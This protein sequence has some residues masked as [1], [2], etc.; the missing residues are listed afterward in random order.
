MKKIQRLF[1]LSRPRFWLYELGPYAIGVLAGA[2]Q[3]AD[4]QD[5]RIFVFAVFFLFPANL[6]IYG[7]NDIFDYETDKL[8]PKKQGYEDLLEPKLH[9]F[10]WKAIGLMTLPFLFFLDWSNGSQI[11]WFLL[12]LFFAGFYSAEPIRAKTKSFLD[13]FFSAGHYVA[14]AVFGY[15]LV[16]GGDI[17]WQYVIAGVLRAMAM[18]A[19]SAIPDIQADREAHMNTVAT[20][21]EKNWTLVYCLILYGLA[22]ILVFTFLGWVSLVLGAVYAAMMIASFFTDDLM[23]LYRYFPWLNSLVGMIL[24]FVVALVHL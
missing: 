7:I 16:S 3:V 10:V 13:G 6:Y 11:F 23:K 20:V 15:V 4:L 14:T 21:L 24:F 9:A 2:L 5:W 12:F 22:A 8:N 1:S 18:H 19:Y 17:A